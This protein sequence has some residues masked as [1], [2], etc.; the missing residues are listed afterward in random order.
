MWNQYKINIKS[1]WN[2]YEFTMVSQ[3]IRLILVEWLY[4]KRNWGRLLFLW[5]SY[6]IFFGCRI[7]FFF[8]VVF[9]FFYIVFLVGLSGSALKVPKLQLMLRLSWAVTIEGKGKVNCWCLKAL[10]VH[11]LNVDV[12]WLRNKPSRWH[13]QQQQDPFLDTQQKLI[14]LLQQ[15]ITNHNYLVM[16]KQQWNQYGINM[17]LRW[18]GSQRR[19]G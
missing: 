12:S 15:L 18:K 17:K 11:C 4:A 19:V 16:H 1:I 9:H 8:E 6:S 3:P 2:D 7:L 14:H 13:N 10:R 5:R